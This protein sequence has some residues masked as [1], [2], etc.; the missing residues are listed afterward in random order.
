MSV[1]RHY[2]KER[3]ENTVDAFEVEATIVRLFVTVCGPSFSLFR[4]NNV[5]LR[6]L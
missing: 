4:R 3:T 1:G 6:S 2:A 5:V